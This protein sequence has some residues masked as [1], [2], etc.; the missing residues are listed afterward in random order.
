MQTAA[1]KAVD[2][3]AQF[4]AHGWCILRGLAS[5]VQV[6][7]WLDRTERLLPDRAVPRASTGVP[8]LL[9]PSLRDPEIATWL[10]LD[11]A[12]ELAAS[13]LFTP[14]VQLLQEALLVKPAS[15]E[16]HLAWH[17]DATYFDFLEPIDVV[18]VRLALTHETLETGCLQ[19]LDRSFLRPHPQSLEHARG[20]G[21]AQVE[22]IFGDT[23]PP[24]AFARVPIELEP[25]DVSVHHCRT[26]HASFGN[27]S[28]RPRRTLVA[29][30]AA[31]H[32][33]V[34][35]SRLSPETLSHFP[36][37]ASGHLDPRPFLVLPRTSRKEI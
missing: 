14:T 25:G 5:P 6:A 1:T 21:S 10:D 16:S 28:D 37:T 35:S 3:V 34:E 8:L 24:D 12:F 27:D 29:H 26:I 13:A 15:S 2:P 11:P 18:S 20:F 17:R 36:T 33:R 23:N 22:S 19:V 9:G 32:C 30:V 31:S 7:R 4:K